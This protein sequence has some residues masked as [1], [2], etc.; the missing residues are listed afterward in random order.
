MSPAP[1][2]S[3]SDRLVRG[4]ALAAVLSLAFAL[5][6]LGLYLYRPATAAAQPASIAAAGL[7]D[8]PSQWSDPV[9]P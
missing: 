6:G 9:G 7:T 3:S 1:F 5:L 2:A 8:S 4:G